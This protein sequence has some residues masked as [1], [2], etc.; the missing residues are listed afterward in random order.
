[1]YKALLADMNYSVL[2]DAFTKKKDCRDMERWGAP[3]TYLR[4]TLSTACSYR[5]WNL[6][7]LL[8][9][10]HL[11][12]T[13]SKTRS[14]TRSKLHLLIISDE[15]NSC[16]LMGS[17]SLLVQIQCS[18]KEPL[19]FLLLIP[20]YLSSLSS[21]LHWFNWLNISD[22]CYLQCSNICKKSIWLAEVSQEPWDPLAPR[23]CRWRPR[24]GELGHL[25][26]Q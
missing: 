11:E 15:W 8:L 17:M 6:A 20:P 5:E 3:I 21:G 16:G 2:A 25:K 14:K 7:Y 12:M 24:C 26:G 22:W 4:Q 13:L 23:S 18:K 19:W 10:H 1:M 9:S